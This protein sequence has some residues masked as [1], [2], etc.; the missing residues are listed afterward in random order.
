MKPHF[1]KLFSALV[2]ALVVGLLAVACSPV[3]GAVAT[4]TSTVAPTEEPTPTQEPTPTEEGGEVIT[5]EAQIEALDI[6]ILE[7][8]PVQVHVTVT[9]YLGDGCTELGDIT[10]TREGNTF[11]ITIT[12]TRPA[13][14]ICTQ[15]LVGFEQNIPL[16]VAGLPAGT[17]TVDVNGFTD[18][19]TLDVDNVLDDQGSISGLVWDDFCNPGGEGEP[20]PTQGPI[21][22]CVTRPGGALAGNGL[23]DNGEQS[24]A[25]V[26]VALGEGA[27]PSTGLATA[28]TDADGAYAFTGLAAG[29]Y[30]VSID[31]LQEPNL[32]ILLPGNF[33]Y[34][35]YD[36][37]SVTISLDPGAALEDVNFGWDYQLR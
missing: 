16:D 15:Q 1:P 27:C 36:E 30:C 6:L 4:P 26:S 5:G 35:G 17:Y 24:L 22:P 37:G 19:F 8:F 32:G 13:E 11:V 12:T 33:T 14:A 23:F 21:S 7:S 34:P 29:E 28:V 9:G 10:Q 3:P 31:A 18:T 2:L 20:A 25:G